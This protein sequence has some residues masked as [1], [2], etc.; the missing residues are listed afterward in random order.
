[1]KGLLVNDGGDAQARFLD[2]EALDAVGQLG[3]GHGPEVRGPR[4][5]SYL[6]DAVA[7]PLGG[8]RG[9]EPAVIQYFERPERPELGELLLG[10][11]AP[12]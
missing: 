12:E 8:F 6:A 1:M 4:N 9:I 7:H 2:Q 5:A 11:H 3:D 10:R